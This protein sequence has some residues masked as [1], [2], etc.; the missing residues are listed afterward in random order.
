MK[1]FLLIVFAALALTACNASAPAPQ[2]A[3]P[4]PASIAVTP[5]NFQMPLGEGCAGDIARYRAIQ[6]NDLAMG[7]VAQS[8]YD[9]I[10]KEIA[11]AEAQC[12]EGH[13]AQARATILA[14]RKRHGYP[15]N[16]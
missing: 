9:K 14:S 6:D 3:A 1:P 7:H 4:E 2:A 11:E 16:L 13:E 8:V 15:T 5:P 12:S 10:K